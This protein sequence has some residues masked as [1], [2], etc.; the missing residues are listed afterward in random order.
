MSL[1]IYQIILLI[2]IGAL[3]GTSMSF[4]GQTGQGVVIPMVLLITGDV[5]LAIAISVLNDLITASAVSIGYVKNKQFK[6]RKDTLI[7]VAVSVFGSFLG[8]LILMTTPLGSIFGWGL[9]AFIIVTGLLILRK[10]LPTTETLKASVRKLTIKILKRK[11][12]EEKLAEIEKKLEAQTFADSDEIEGIIPS[13]SRLFYILAIGLGLYIGLNSGLFGA[14]SGFALTLILVMLYGY[15]LKK[16][17]GTALLLSIMVCT[18]SFIIYQI[19][20]ITLMSQ[21]YINLEITL[22]LAIGSITTGIIASTY[23]QNLNAKAMG[24]GM[25]IAM[26]VLGIVSL[27]FFF[28]S[29]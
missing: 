12:N 10:G 18:S 27:I 29:I 21:F 17:V 2:L 9:P 8:V 4:V 19:L 16:G 3:V 13:G 5:L 6:I 28:V 23:I 7:L 14:N 15:P 25:A 20:G 1:E 26:I 24:R 11:G 22:Y